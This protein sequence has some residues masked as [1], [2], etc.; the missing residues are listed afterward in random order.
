MNL[1]PDDPVRGLLQ[2]YAHQENAVR[3]LEQCRINPDFNSPFR[4]DLEFYIPQICCIYIEGGLEDPRDVINLILNAAKSDMFFSHRIWFFFQSLIFASDEEG[5]VKRKASQQ[6]VTQLKSICIECQQLLCL[7]NSQDLIYY[8]IK[9]GMLKQYPSFIKHLEDKLTSMDPDQEIRN[10]QTP[11]EKQIAEI[12]KLI[13]QIAASRF[14]QAFKLIKSY[15]EKQVK[16]AS[17]QEEV[18][19]ALEKDEKLYGID[20]APETAQQLGLQAEQQQVAGGQI[21]KAGDGP[22]GVGADA[23]MA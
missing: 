8:I 15:Q 4:N 22:R 19:I 9:F 13:E 2:L 16:K 23:V 12:K 1:A 18:M 5:K 17:N 3:D 20:E 7:V 6:I 21:F 10:A 14:E 11:K